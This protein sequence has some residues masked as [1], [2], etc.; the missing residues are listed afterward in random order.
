MR[1]GMSATTKTVLQ[2]A[3]SSVPQTPPMVFACSLS[4][5]RGRCSWCSGASKAKSSWTRR[6]PAACSTVEQ[7]AHAL[8]WGRCSWCSGACMAEVCKQGVPDVP[9][10]Q[11]TLGCGGTLWQ[12][13]QQRGHGCARAT[14]K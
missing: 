4:V 7:A 13:A 5:R 6:K 8:V 12:A 3:V 10:R 11:R 2:H 1:Q 9:A 14:D